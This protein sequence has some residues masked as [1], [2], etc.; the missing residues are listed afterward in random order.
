MSKL[1][2]KP[3]VL[4]RTSIFAELMS[5]RKRLHELLKK[6]PHVPKEETADSMAMAGAGSGDVPG[7]QPGELNLHNEVPPQH[8]PIFD[9]SFPS[10]SMP[11]PNVDPSGQ[12]VPIQGFADYTVGVQNDPLLRH[13]TPRTA[14]H[15]SKRKKRT[16]VI[17]QVAGQE[18]YYLGKPTNS[19]SGSESD[20]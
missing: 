16:H 5:D 9:K 11:Y 19:E 20:D 13:V 1:V 12:V 8:I 6:H 14:T 10:D 15:S 7:P 4:V 18:R 17:P 2:I 3:M